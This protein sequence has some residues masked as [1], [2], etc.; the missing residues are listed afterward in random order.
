MDTKTNQK[1]EEYLEILVKQN[2]PIEIAKRGILLGIFTSLGATIVF[3][4]IILL[5]SR[6]INQINTLPIIQDI[7]RETKLDVLIEKELRKLE[8]NVSEKI[9]EN[10][11][12]VSIYFSEKDIFYLLDFNKSELLVNNNHSKEQNI[13]YDKIYKIDETIYEAITSEYTNLKNSKKII[14]FRKPDKKAVQITFFVKNNLV[15]DQY[16]LWEEDEEINDYAY[17][18][19]LKIKNIIVGIANT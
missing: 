16:F 7:L 11:T 5:S 14:N 8:Q 9:E 10:I 19:L 13:E 18:E 15:I 6:L 12:G 4:L 2:K 3:S 1:I 17:P